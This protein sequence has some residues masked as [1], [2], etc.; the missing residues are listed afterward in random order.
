MWACVRYAVLYI[1]IFCVVFLPETCS[2]RTGRGLKRSLEAVGFVLAEFQP[3]RSHGDPIRDIFLLTFKMHFLE[4]ELMSKTDVYK[5]EL[6]P[7]PPPQRCAAKFSFFW[8]AQQLS[9]ICLSPNGEI[10]V[11]QHLST[12]DDMSNC[13]AGEE[14]NELYQKKPMSEKGTLL[15]IKRNRC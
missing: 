2:R 15:L 9:I 7:Q 11:V 8:F 6:T 13:Q 10:N 1:L 5:K 12:N 4:T 14:R 3:K